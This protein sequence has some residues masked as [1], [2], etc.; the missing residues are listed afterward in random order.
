MYKGAPI[1]IVSI[2]TYKGIGFTFY[3]ELYKMNSSLNVTNTI[4][5]FTSGAIA[6]IIGQTCNQFFYSTINTNYLTSF[7]S[8]GHI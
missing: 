3:E 5:N 7:L 6:G 1:A 2:M 8:F 4:L